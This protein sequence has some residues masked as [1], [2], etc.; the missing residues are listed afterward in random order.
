MDRRVSRSEYPLWVKASV[1]GIP[2]RGGVWAFVVFSLACAAL[3]LMRG[4][5]T[6][7]FLDVGF[8]LACAAVPYWLSIRWIDRNGSWD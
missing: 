7:R 6:G 1:W 4:A 3:L 8:L 2:G 5:H